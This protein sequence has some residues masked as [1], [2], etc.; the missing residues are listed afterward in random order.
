MMNTMH[1]Q[2]WAALGSLPLTGRAITAVPKRTLVAA[3]AASGADR[4]LWAPCKPLHRLVDA[5]ID[6]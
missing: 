4:P 2:Q 1:L 6:N 5:Q 3:R